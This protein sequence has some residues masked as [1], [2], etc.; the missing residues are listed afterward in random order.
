MNRATCTGTVTLTTIVS[1]VPLASETITL[2]V[3]PAVFGSAVIDTDDAEP[4]VVTNALISAGFAL[5]TVYEPTPPEIAKELLV[6]PVT[7]A[8][9]DGAVLISAPGAETVTTMLIEAPTESLITSV[10]EPT[11][12]ALMVSVDPAI[13]AL[14]TV[15]LPLLTLY[16]LF[17]PPS[18]TPPKMVYT[19]PVPF[20]SVKLAGASVKT[21]LGCG[22]V[23]EI[24]TG[25]LLPL[26]SLIATVATPTALATIDRLEPVSV[27]VTAAGLLLFTTYVPD[28]P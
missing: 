27:V 11:A 17:T 24:N 26:V 3:P 9:G 18:W 4:D 2:A 15:G 21:E 5:C 23:T 25:G 10:E 28:P 1:W 12:R 20:A 6:V 7:S 13:V 16:L 19:A 22:T 14:A 8:R